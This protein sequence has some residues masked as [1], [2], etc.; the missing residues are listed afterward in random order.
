MQRNW[1]SF[2]LKY[3]KPDV[4]HPKNSEKEEKATIYAIDTLS[5]DTVR[6]QESNQNLSKPISF[7][8][9]VQVIVPD[10]MTEDNLKDIRVNNIDRIEIANMFFRSTGEGGT[11]DNL[12]IL[13]QIQGIHDTNNFASVFPPS[14][15]A[16]GMAGNIAHV[17]GQQ[18]MEKIVLKS[19]QYGEGKI[20]NINVKV[21]SLAGVRIQMQG[22]ITLLIYLSRGS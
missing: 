20:E 10:N 9:T 7:I 2:P 15:N 8:K 11:A 4:G 22:F 21:F 13:V 18:L 14:L 1:Q 12:P 3:A 16:A 6:T 17:S 5:K 19:Y